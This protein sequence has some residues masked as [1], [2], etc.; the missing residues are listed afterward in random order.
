VHTTVQRIDSA[1]FC[2]M[3]QKLSVLTALNTG[4]ALMK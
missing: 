2:N 4:V 3:L 1:N